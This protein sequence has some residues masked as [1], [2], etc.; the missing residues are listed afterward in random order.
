M[1]LKM[2]FGKCMAAIL[3]RRQCVKLVFLHNFVGLLSSLLLLRMPKLF[4]PKIQES[5]NIYWHD[6]GSWNSSSCK[7]RTNLVFIVNAN[8]IGWDTDSTLIYKWIWWW[9]MS[10][11]LMITWRCDENMGS[12]LF[13][14][15]EILPVP[16]QQCCKDTCQIYFRTL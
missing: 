6:T 10:C 9:Q 14:R 1:Q 16:W 15:S 4:R 13:D 5:H 2:S 8:P 11:L 3:A 7:T 12:E